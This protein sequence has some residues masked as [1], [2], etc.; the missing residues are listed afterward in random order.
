M[1]F[2]GKT[3]INELRSMPN[4][5]FHLLFMNSVKKLSTDEGKKEEANKAVAE[6]FEGMV[7]V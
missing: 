2:K 5:L 1:H 4:R 7:D 3:T 6:A